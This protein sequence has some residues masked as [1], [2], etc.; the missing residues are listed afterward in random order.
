MYD[1]ITSR[2]RFGVCWLAF[3]FALQSVNLLHLQAVT[4][5]LDRGYE[6]SR[7]VRTTWKHEMVQGRTLVQY[8][9]ELLIFMDVEK[10]ELPADTC[11]KILLHAPRNEERQCPRQSSA[12]KPLASASSISSL[13]SGLGLSSATQ[14]EPTVG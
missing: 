7:H 13:K 4:K 10:L 3:A 9:L 5:E 8:L 2:V 12:R 1:A 6:I 11:S 14:R